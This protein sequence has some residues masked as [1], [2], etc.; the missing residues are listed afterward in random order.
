M[1]VHNSDCSS[2]SKITIFFNPYLQYNV[3]TGSKHKPSAQE[4][5]LVFIKGSPY[6][7]AKDFFDIQYAL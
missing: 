2:K 1:L 4:V 3:Y 5:M 6:K 7:N